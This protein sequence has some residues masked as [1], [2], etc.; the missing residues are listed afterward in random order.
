MDDD[1]ESMTSTY[2]VIGVLCGLW[3]LITGFILV[4]FFWG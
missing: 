1:K 3:A 2:V 4:R